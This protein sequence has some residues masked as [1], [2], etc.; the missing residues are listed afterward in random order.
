MIHNRRQITQAKKIRIQTDKRIQSVCLQ[1]KISTFFALLL[2]ARR[3]QVAKYLLFTLRVI[4]LLIFNCYTRTHLYRNVVSVESSTI[5]RDVDLPRN[6]RSPQIIGAEMVVV[7][8]RVSKTSTKPKP[9]VS[10]NHTGVT[11]NTVILSPSVRYCFTTKHRKFFRKFSR[12]NVQRT[13]EK[14]I[15]CRENLTRDVGQS[16]SFLLFTESQV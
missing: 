16:V 14:R 8:S 2:R 4:T 7:V 9:N 6:I 3:Y 15:Y 1:L 13:A 10:E 11:F 12:M 5:Q